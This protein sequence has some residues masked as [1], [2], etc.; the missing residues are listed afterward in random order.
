MAQ[1]YY[2]DEIS[3]AFPLTADSDGRYRTSP[4]MVGSDRYGITVHDLPTDHSIE[5]EGN[6]SRPRLPGWEGFTNVVSYAIQNRQLQASASAISGD[7][8]FALNWVRIKPT[9][10]FY[11]TD[12]ASSNGCATSDTGA[13]SVQGH[14]RFIRLSIS[15]APLTTGLT[16]TRAYY[17]DTSNIL[18]G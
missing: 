15:A 4:I 6:N 5:L 12:A 14:F 13:F 3:F 2:A 9:S 8:L 10:E 18:R 11:F 16:C 7:P 17:M 1:F